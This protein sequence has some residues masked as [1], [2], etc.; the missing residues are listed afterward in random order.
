MAEDKQDL[1]LVEVKTKTTKDFGEPVEEIDYFKKKK[2][3]QL[4]RALSQKYPNKNIRI[5]VIGIE[6]ETDDSSKV[7]IEHIENAVE[8]YT[9]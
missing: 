2:L 7:E 4:A 6:I 5:D 3:S 1:V 9:P 8:V